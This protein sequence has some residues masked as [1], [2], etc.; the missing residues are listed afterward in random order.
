MKKGKNISRKSF[1]SIKT[2]V[3]FGGKSVNIHFNKD[4][5]DKM[6]K[7]VSNILKAIEYGSDLD[8]AI[9]N[10]KQKENKIYTVTITARVNK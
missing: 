6:F 1:G 2:K 5:K 8:I 10:T 3:Y 9:P 7:L 4:D